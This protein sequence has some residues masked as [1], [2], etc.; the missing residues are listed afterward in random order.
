MVKLTSLLIIQRSKTIYSPRSAAELGRHSVQLAVVVM[1]GAI[2]TR[3][4]GSFVPFWKID[5]VRVI[6]E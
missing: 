6:N 4:S 3:R 5:D 2:I 1:A